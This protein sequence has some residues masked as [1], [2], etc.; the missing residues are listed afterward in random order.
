MK[1]A[2]SRSEESPFRIEQARFFVASLLRMTVGQGIKLRCNCP[3]HQSR[4][5]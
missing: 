5:Y 2:D 3:D 4:R 1:I